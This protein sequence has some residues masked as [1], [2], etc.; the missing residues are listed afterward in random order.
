[1]TDVEVQIL[2][3]QMIILNAL[4]NIVS[5]DEIQLQNLLRNSHD[6]TKELLG[7]ELRRIRCK[8]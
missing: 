3:N 2:A 5:E 6:L 7:E 4:R 1:M 8:F